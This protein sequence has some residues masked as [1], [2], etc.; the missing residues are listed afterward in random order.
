MRRYTFEHETVMSVVSARDAFRK[1]PEIQVKSSAPGWICL[2]IA[3]QLP[4][5]ERVV[6]F[7]RSHMLS[8]V[9]S[10]LCEQITLAMD[11]L[12]GNALEHGCKVDPTLDVELS[13]IRTSRSILLYLRDAGPGFS[14]ESLNH[15]AVNNPPEDPLRHTSFRSQMGLRPGGFGIML[16]KRIA[17]ELIYNETGNEVL[18]IKYL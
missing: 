14:L 12:L 11:E 15:A 13:Y 3:P 10:E 2:H 16:V 1:T 9:S 7:F 8:D 17:D 4:L 18:F 5:K 6:A